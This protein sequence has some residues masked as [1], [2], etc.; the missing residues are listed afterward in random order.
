M[1]P[2]LQI[3][4]LALQT[5]QVA[6]LLATAAALTLASRHAA[7]AGLDGDHLYSAGLY[8]LLAGIVAGRLGHVVAYWS[9]Y[10]QQPL[11]IIGLN[12]GAFLLWPGVAGGLAFAAWYVERHRLPWPRVLDAAAA[13]LLAALVVTS[14]GAYFAGRAYGSVS[15][16]PWAVDLW[17]IRRHPVQLYEAATLALGLAL[18][19]A[20][21]RAIDR[22]GRTAEIALLVYGLTRWLWEPFRAD[23]PLILFGLRA[24][25]VIGLACILFAAQRLL[26]PAQMQ[27]EG[28]AE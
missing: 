13:G 2:I 9:A 21:R 8:G 11:E 4:P 6:L 19:L 27:T 22:G 23:S 7:W 14:I 25:Q 10:Q 18:I 3:G 20:Y 16:L 5:Y 15:D 17:G 28:T 26:R 24:P 12:T 1:T